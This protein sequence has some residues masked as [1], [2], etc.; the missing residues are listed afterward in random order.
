[1]PDS[2]F[3]NRVQTCTAR[4]GLSHSSAAMCVHGLKEERL[5]ECVQGNV[6]ER[7]HVSCASGLSRGSLLDRLWILF[8]AS[9]IVKTFPIQCLNG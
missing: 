6:K 3:P 5:R 7:T 1:M 8:N 2:F 4:L 9:D